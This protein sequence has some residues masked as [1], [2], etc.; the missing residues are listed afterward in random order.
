MEEASHIKG[1]PKTTVGQACE[2]CGGLATM[3]IKVGQSRAYAACDG[4][5][6]HRELKQRARA[7]SCSGC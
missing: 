1:G 3:S 2:V 4:D 6:C 7:D 5:D